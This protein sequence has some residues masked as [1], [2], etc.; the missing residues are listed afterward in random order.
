M[1]LIPTTQLPY[2][3]ALAAALGNAA[4][5][6]GVSGPVHL[7]ALDKWKMISKHINA[8]TA[9]PN[10]DV[11]KDAVEQWHRLENDWCTRSLD[12][13]LHPMAVLSLDDVMVRCVLFLRCRSRSGGVAH[14]YT[15]A[16]AGGNKVK[17]NSHEAIQCAQKPR[18]GLRGGPAM[19]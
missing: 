15:R 11:T 17:D 8:N 18:L 4:L 7:M 16:H 2:A 13:A 10:P 6:D 1:N 5:P 9:P 14:T 12:V 3:A 19:W